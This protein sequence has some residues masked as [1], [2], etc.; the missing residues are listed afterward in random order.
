MPLAIDRDQ[1]LVFCSKLWINS[2]EKGLVRLILTTAQKYLLDEILAGLREGVHHFV[3]L[4]CRQAQASTLCMAFTLYWEFK[5]QGMNGVVVTEGTFSK[6]NFRQTY[7][8]FMDNLTNEDP[9]WRQPVTTNNRDMLA[10]ANQSRLTF[11]NANQRTKGGLGRGVGIS[12]V[13]GTEVGFW[14]DQLSY[15]S[16]MASVAQQNENRLFIFESTANGNNMFKG[17]CQTAKKAMTQKFIFVGWWIHDDYQ[18]PESDPRYKTYWNGQLTQEEQ[19]W[20]PVVEQRYKVK[21][22]GKRLAWWRWMFYEKMGEDL[23]ALYQEYPP[24]PED[25]FQFSGSP[26]ISK[27]CLQEHYEY[28][29]RSEGATKWRF[30]FGKNFGETEIEQVGED[31]FEDL[32]IWE[33]PRIDDRIR[34]VIGVDPSHGVNEFSDQAVICVLRC[35]ADK[36]EQVAE[37]SAR[38]V[39]TYRLAWVILFLAALY[40]PAL[41]NIEMAGGGQST[42]Q[43]IQRVEMDLGINYPAELRNELGK[44]Q[45]YFYKRPDT[46]TANYTALHWESSHKNR[47]RLLAEVRNFFE[48]GIAILHSTDLINEAAAI[49]VDEEGY[50]GAPEGDNDDRVFGFGVAVMGFLENIIYDIGGAPHCAYGAFEDERKIDRG[51]YTSDDLMHKRLMD[52][53]A[54]RV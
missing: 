32:T 49:V 20:V 51:T 2:K 6:Q 23:E 16:L 37:F 25:A 36:V 50:I 5:H 10:F 45:H 3:V 28:A 30:R 12:L 24:L 1:F 17:L 15:Q 35:Y 4:K 13:H 41:I 40:Q 29:D 8:D 33:R 42:Y 21:V 47:N 27:A 14:R 26:F 39:P 9:K 44:V 48:R 18:V 11:T 52:F 54:D 34:Y 43:E 38:G 19:K 53:I 7:T 46:I 22:D 31:G